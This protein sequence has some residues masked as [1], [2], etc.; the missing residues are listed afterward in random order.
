[1]LQ[2]KSGSGSGAKHFN[3]SI[4]TLTKKK[5]KKKDPKKAEM[6]SQLSLTGQGAG[7]ISEI[8]VTREPSRIQTSENKME[9]KARNSIKMAHLA[10]DSAV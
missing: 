3:D 9:K 2:Y 6:W 10:F 5:K 4:L 1:M 7:N 8:C